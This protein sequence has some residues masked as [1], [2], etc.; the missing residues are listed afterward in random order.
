MG[1]KHQNRN[2]A[3]RRN[4]K[5]EN[6]PKWI[7]LVGGF[8]TIAAIITALWGVGKDLYGLYKERNPVF[9]Y[10]TN[11]DWMSMDEVETIVTDESKVVVYAYEDNDSSV[12]GY[13][14]G[15]ALT[16]LFSNLSNTDREITSF[17]VFA[18]NIVEDLSPDLVCGPIDSS[19]DTIAL[20]FYNNGW[21]ES[22]PIHI[23][24]DRIECV[25]DNNASCLQLSLGKN[26]QTTWIFD[27]LQPG[28][29]REFSLLMKDDFIIGESGHCDGSVMF[30]LYL[31]LFLPDT[32]YDEEIPVL[33]EVSESKLEVHIDGM[34]GGV[35]IS[36][37]VKI[38]T[39]GKTWVKKYPADQKLP[40]NKTVRLP[41]LIVPE[42]SC[43][44]SIRVEFELSNGEIVKSEELADTYVKVPYYDDWSEYLDGE[45]LDWDNIDSFTSIYFPFKSSS[46]ILP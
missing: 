44:L 36:Y 23:S 17:T 13:R 34:G 29:W 11:F 30:C 45:L 31:D 8:A 2:N 40:A 9:A 27:S 7:V 38:P 32:G 18:D 41:I 28:D 46:T 6:T 1:N 4:G 16:A 26:A 24:V 10:E 3:R 43:F 14:D 21:G 33:L 12:N 42:K 5:K 37:V 35:D 15:V 39:D 22:G 19:A 20:Y 25:E